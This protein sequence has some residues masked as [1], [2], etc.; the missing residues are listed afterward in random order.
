[1][2]IKNVGRIKKQKPL[3]IPLFIPH[4]GCPHQCAFCNQKVIAGQKA[5][6]IS[7]KAVRRQIDQFLTYPSEKRETVQIS[8]YGGNF[9]GLE[10]ESIRALLDE[11]CRF[12]EKGKAESIRFSTRPDTISRETLKLISSYPIRTVELGVQSMDDRVLEQARRGHTALDTKNALLLLKETPYDIGLQIMTGLPGDNEASTLLTA[13][14]LAEFSPAFVRIYPALVLK[15]SLLARWYETGKFHPLT[16]DEA[17]HRVKTL[18]LFFQERAIPVIRMGL[19]AS[20]TLE[21]D[22]NVLAGPYHPAFGH[23]VL[24][25]I[26]LDKASELLKKN[27]GLTGT[28]TFCVRLQNISRMRGQNN[29]NIKILKKRFRLDSIDVIPDDGMAADD[30]RLAER[31]PL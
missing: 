17:I 12:I 26:Y 16:L 31:E 18:Y 13:Q 27:P 10:P 2:N 14:K 24:S 11:A 22:Q 30:I 29:R 9:L 5:G 21:A 6:K 15:D 25:S 19:Q 23:L 3:I 1:M 7:L 8:F 28:A 20:D 4:A